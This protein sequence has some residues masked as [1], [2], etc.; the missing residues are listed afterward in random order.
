MAN[1]GKEFEKRFADDWRESVP[2]SLCYRLYDVTMGYKAIAN[3]GD[4][5]CYK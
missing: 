4:F 2:G 1:R 5:I 3:A